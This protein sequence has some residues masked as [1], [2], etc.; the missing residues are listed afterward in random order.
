[1]KI[2][3]I[4]A[5]YIEEYKVYGAFAWKDGESGSEKVF[6]ESFGKSIDEAIKFLQITIEV[7]MGG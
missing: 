7:K 4:E 1:M 5:E 6:A 3:K 2:T